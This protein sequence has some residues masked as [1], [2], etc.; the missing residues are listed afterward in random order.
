[1]RKV[2]LVGKKF[3]RLL[4]VEEK[5]KNNQGRILWRC[6]CS[7]GR[8]SIV[9]GANLHGKGTRSCGCLVREV[10]GKRATLRNTTHGC[11]GIPA[12]RSWVR[13]V[14]RCTNPKNTSYKGYGGR[15]IK[16][17]SRWRVFENF[18]KDMG[19][20]PEG[21]SIDRINNDGNYE[22]SNCRWATRKE[23]QH[24]RRLSK[25]NTTGSR[26][27]YLNKRTQEYYAHL[28]TD[29]IFHYL[30]SFKQIEDAITAR[31]MAEKR[32]WI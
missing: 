2:N 1:M 7:C 19:D 22:P 25:N 14:A 30:G 27:V 4:V 21:K 11:Y 6:I 16:V 32:Y 10:V 9:S 15:G 3:G 17:C 20:R 26:G 28:K 29:G 12:H 18:Y 31:T 23:Q 5:G 24:N 8:E 13:M